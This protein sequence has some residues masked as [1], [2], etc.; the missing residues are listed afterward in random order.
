[1][2]NQRRGCGCSALFSLIFLFCIAAAI[3]R[4]PAY[5]DSN[6]DKTAGVLAEKQETI[7]VVAG[8]WYRRFQIIASFT[9]PGQRLDHRAVCDVDG[10]TYDSLHMGDSISV[11]YLMNLLSQPFIPATH[12]APCTSWASI[13]LNPEVVRKVIIAAATFLVIFFLHGVLRIRI[14][15]L[16]Y[17]PW[18]GLVFLWLAIPRTE[19][20][21]GQ[22]QPAAATVQHVTTIST[23]LTGHDNHG[24][25][26]KQPYQIVQLKFVPKG[27]DGPVIAVDK[28]DLNSVANLH[29]GQTVNIT[30][31]AANPRVARVEGGTRSFPRSAFFLVLLIALILT[32]I[33]F[34]LFVISWFVHL[35]HRNPAARASRWNVDAIRRFRRG[36]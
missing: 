22:P 21:P 23:L 34:V 36:L 15:G 1:M 18:I 6:G 9:I 16:L 10:Q 5:I 30:Y 20:V 13:N 11:H 7:R 35:F 29:E 28:I 17:V 12:L 27:M 32:A 24:L 2:R 8:E 3:F 19:P 4:W 33:A 26:L 14:A 25:Q 31:D